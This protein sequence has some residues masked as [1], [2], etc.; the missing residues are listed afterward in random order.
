MCV[1]VD[2]D[3]K[4]VPSWMLG[5]RSSKTA[6]QFVTDLAGRLRNRV[7]LTSDSHRPYLE[8]LDG[9]FG[10]DADYAQLVKIYGAPP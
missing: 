1:A 6:A 9:A 7:Q 4:L 8:A 2:A 5:D 10:N 3:S